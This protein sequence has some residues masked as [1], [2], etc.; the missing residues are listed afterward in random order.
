MKIHEAN[1]HL[2]HEVVVVNVGVFYDSEIS[3]VWNDFIKIQIRFFK[4][5]ERQIKVGKLK[6]QKM[7]RSLLSFF[8]R[9]RFS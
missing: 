2:P 3:M 9:L 8:M 6:A 7:S 4:E 5:K 1:E